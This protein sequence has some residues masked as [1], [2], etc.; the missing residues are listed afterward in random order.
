M[1]W[2]KLTQIEKQ[3]VLEQI[4]LATGFQEFIIEKDWWVV[5]TL[6]LISQ[7]EIANQLSFKGGTS[8]GKAW[9]IITRF[10][11]D[12][13]LAINR[14]F[15]GFSDDISGNQIRKKLRPMSNQYI[16][17][18]FLSTLQNAF[19]DAGMEDVKLC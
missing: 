9:N 16:S 10:S 3:N 14:E 7:M 12:V 11:E 5:Q 15:F 4:R 17:N 8:L 18:D 13:D 2:T 1:N 19:D 6:R